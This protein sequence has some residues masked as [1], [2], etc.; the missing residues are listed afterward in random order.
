MSVDEFLTLLILNLFLRQLWA[1][2]ETLQA[3]STTFKDLH[4]RQIILI[5]TFWSFFKGNS[6]FDVNHHC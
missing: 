1:T 4:L 5:A 6:F 3:S 2:F